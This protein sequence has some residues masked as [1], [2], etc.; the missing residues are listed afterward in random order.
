MSN[1]FQCPDCGKSYTR[2]NRLVGKA[3]ACECGRR[4]LVPHRES[5]APPLASEAGAISSPQS[6]LRA[7]PVPRAGKPLRAT[8]ARVARWADPVAPA[9][10][11]PLTED[12]LLDDAPQGGPLEAV[13]VPFSP[14]PSP[15]AWPPAAIPLAPPAIRPPPPLAKPKR[16]GNSTGARRKDE[17]VE[18]VGNLAAGCIFFGILPL[19]AA[20]V[21]YSILGGA[22][23]AV[24]HLERSMQPPAKLSSMPPA[25]GP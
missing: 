13:P 16:R 5:T 1:S 4:F 21:L 14:S 17:Q 25:R 10:P 8:P 9:Q 3:V 12:D 24:H 11:I 18:T 23:R 7:T 20:L 15:A 2:E 22:F 19:I 6:P